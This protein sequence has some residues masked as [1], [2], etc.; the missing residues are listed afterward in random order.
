[1]TGRQS[2]FDRGRPLPGWPQEARLQGGE[3]RKL[4]TDLCQVAGEGMAFGAAPSAI[5]E[6]LALLA[7]PLTDFLSAP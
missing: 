2:D 7:S 1:L 5:E 3:L 4:C 6:L